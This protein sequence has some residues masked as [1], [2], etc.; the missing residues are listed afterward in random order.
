M[1]LFQVPLARRGGSP[2]FRPFHI[3]KAMWLMHS[4]GQIGRKELSEQLQIGEGSTR[5]LLSHMEEHGLSQTSRQGISLS[6]LAY[7]FIRET[8]FFARVVSAGALTVDDH[9]F[10]IR[11]RGFSSNVDKGIEQRD[12]AMKVGASGASTL[13]FNDRLMF[14]DGFPAEDID[15]EAAGRIVKELKLRDGDQVIIGSAENIGLAMDGAFA[16]AVLTLES[17]G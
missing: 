15:A 16:A 6:D 7:G 11:L 9:D 8:G 1:S 3:F 2:L 10:A 13:L 12:E 17:L 14:S 4:G 5:K